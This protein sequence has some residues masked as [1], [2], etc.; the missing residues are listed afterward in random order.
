[1]RNFFLKLNLNRALHNPKRK[2][3]AHNLRTANSIAILFDASE[4]P[5]SQHIKEWS[6]T[7]EKDGKNVQ[8]M[9]FIAQPQA[10]DNPGFPYC[11][12]KDF[13]LTGRWKNDALDQFIAAKPHLLVSVNPKNLLPISMLA[14]MSN[15]EMKAG[16]PSGWNN[17]YDLILEVPE[18][19]NI[20]YF[21]EQLQFYLDKIN[22]ANEPSRTI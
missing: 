12:S 13:T 3:V 19:K 16:N 5:F 20:K 17:D 1:M 21:L 8:L 2:R 14:A 15:A 18:N 22:L 7:L 6:A 4:Q 9:G 10:T 11:S